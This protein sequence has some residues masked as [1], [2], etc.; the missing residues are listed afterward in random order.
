MPIRAI[1]FALKLVESQGY[2]QKKQYQQALD[3]FLQCY[4]CLGDK[5]G[6]KAKFFDLDI[7][8]AECAFATDKNDIVLQKIGNAKSK[9]KNYV[10]LSKFDVAYLDYFVDILLYQFGMKKSHDV[11]VKTKQELELANDKI[12]LDFPIN[13]EFLIR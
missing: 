4:L 8:T 9:Y 6:A 1:R 10:K 7:M 2:L 13:E 3:G 12:K 5:R 11:S